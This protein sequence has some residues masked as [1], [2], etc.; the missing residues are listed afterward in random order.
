MRSILDILM[1]WRSLPCIWVYLSVSEDVRSLINEDLYV[2]GFSKD[3][4]GLHKALLRGGIFRRQ[5]YWRIQD[6]T[7]PLYYL[8]RVCYRPSNGLEIS[9]TSGK[10]G[11]GLMIRHGYS[12]IIFCHSIGKHFTTYQNV[13]IGRGKMI[14]GNDVPIIGD[15]VT[16]YTGAVVIG[17][18][19]IGDNAV[20]GAGAVVVKNVPADAVVVSQPMRVL[21]NGVEK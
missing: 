5:F 6:V 16:V 17:G 1:L 4:Y 13:T 7:K 10:I 18:I 19:H 8:A 3:I 12:T 21:V 15:N 11:G 9:A 14:D 2:Y 20:I